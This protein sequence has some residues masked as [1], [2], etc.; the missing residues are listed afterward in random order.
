MKPSFFLGGDSTY[1]YIYLCIYI[2]EW[3]GPLLHSRLH[4]QL[5]AQRQGDDLRHRR[6][7]LLANAFCFSRTKPSDAKIDEVM[8]IR[9]TQKNTATKKDK[10]EEEEDKTPKTETT[11]K[12]NDG[13]HKQKRNDPDAPDVFR[14]LKQ[15]GLTPPNIG[16][17]NGGSGGSKWMDTAHTETKKTRQHKKETLMGHTKRN[18]TKNKKK[19]W[20]AFRPDLWAFGPLGQSDKKFLSHGI[21]RILGNYLESPS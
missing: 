17:S 7:V 4:R 11:T 9:D 2:P 1:I 14:A 18:K 3:A 15:P 21:K 16:V 6:H 20:P 13:T 5:L 19:A 10:K 8:G 12:K